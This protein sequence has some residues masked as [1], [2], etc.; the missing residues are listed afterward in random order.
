M[1]DRYEPELTQ[2]GDGAVE[3]AF[4]ATRVEVGEDGGTR[5][6][7]LAEDRGDTTV[8]SLLIC[9]STAS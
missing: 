9:L 3:Q 1:G 5:Y 7:Q 6:V 2:L 4:E 8:H